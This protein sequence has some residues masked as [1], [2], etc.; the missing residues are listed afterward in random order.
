MKKI[1][2][3]LSFLSFSGCAAVFMAPVSAIVQGYV[4]WKD[5]EAT[6][7]YNTDIDTTYRSLKHATDKLNLKIVTD[8]QNKDKKGYYLVIGDKDKFKVKIIPTKNNVT[9]IKIRINFMG[10]KPYAELLYKEIDNNLNTIQF[11][12]GKPI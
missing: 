4:M 3:I 6:K 1:I 10:D 5:G 9:Q 7:Y 12:N 8:N 11:K 2:L